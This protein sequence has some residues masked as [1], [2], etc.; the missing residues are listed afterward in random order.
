MIGSISSVKEGF[1]FITEE[2]SRKIW[3]FSFYDFQTGSLPQEGMKVSFE[4]KTDYQKFKHD[5]EEGVLRDAVEGGHRNPKLKKK[6][7]GGGMPI[8]PCAMKVIPAEQE[9]QCAS[10]PNCND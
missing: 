3:Y 1:A 4:R 8:A 9:E 10:K 7:R 5:L 6:Q 2:G